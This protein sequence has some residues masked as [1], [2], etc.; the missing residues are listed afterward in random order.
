M[1]KVLALSILLGLSVHSAH[2]QDVAKGPSFEVASITPC[3]PGTPE[4]PG[5]HAGMVR[6]IYPGGNFN[7]KATTVK[8]LFEWAYGI[9]PAQH[10]GDPSWM[11]SER[12]DIVAKAEG[13]P[14]DPQMKMMARTLLAERFKLKFHT[15]IKEVPVILVSLGKTE[16]KLYPSKEGEV[17]SIRIMPQMGP[18]QK[19]V[20]FHVVA[21]RFTLTE[22]NE[23]FARQIGRVIVDQT[24]MKGEYNFTLDM[25][26]D[27]ERPNPLDPAIVI[28][29]MRDQLG[30]T[31]K[32]QKGPVEIFVIDSVEPVASGN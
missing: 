5:E 23:T 11:D 3:K 9:L 4:P 1:N 2:C 6:F 30:L 20:S 10:T 26:P 22:L 15:E 31:V 16:P 29:A 8:Y 21:T 18:D 7:A 13:N 28:G 32:S 17:H 14:S 24:G 12:Y 25:T 19:P 27:E